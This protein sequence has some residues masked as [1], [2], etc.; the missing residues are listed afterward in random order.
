MVA[1]R[2]E[3]PLYSQPTVFLL[4]TDKGGQREGTLMLVVTIVVVVVVIP[5]SSKTMTLMYN[6][7][8]LLLQQN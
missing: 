1:A 6:A 7:L 3:M 4:K 8:A 5:R 2:Q